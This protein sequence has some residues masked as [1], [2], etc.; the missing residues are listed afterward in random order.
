MKK[1]Y[2]LAVWE[3]FG[4]RWS[5]YYFIWRL[6]DFIWKLSDFIWKLSY[7]ICFYFQAPSVSFQINPASD[8]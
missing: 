4:E 5:L 2:S 7:F 1:T 6:S 8:K 3:G